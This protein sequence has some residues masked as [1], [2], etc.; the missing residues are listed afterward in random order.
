MIALRANLTS[1]PGPGRDPGPKFQK[2]RNAFFGVRRASLEFEDTFWL[3]VG[4]KKIQNSN[5]EELL[6]PRSAPTRHPTIRASMQASCLLCFGFAS[7]APDK[8][9][10][11]P[12][13]SPEPFRYAAVFCIFCSRIRHPSACTTFCSD[14]FL[15]DWKVI[16]WILSTTLVAMPA[17]PDLFWHSGHQIISTFH[18][19]RFSRSGFA[20]LL[21]FR[22]WISQLYCS[23]VSNFCVIHSC[24]PDTIVNIL[25][26]CWACIEPRV[27]PYPRWKNK[28]RNVIVGRFELMLS[29]LVTVLSRSTFGVNKIKI[30]A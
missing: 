20:I 26:P 2:T 28:P 22:Q 12:F 19:I 15:F 24:Q 9:S 7:A 16:P 13:R 14:I 30:V 17:L 27:G 4:W 29:Q 1:R 3:S 6:K 10:A 25:S 8:F 18:R 5:G 11:Y 23:S 21:Q